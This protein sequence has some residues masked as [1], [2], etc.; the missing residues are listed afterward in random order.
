MSA[1]HGDTPLT[2]FLA[3]LTQTQLREMKAEV[4]REIEATQERLEH[5]QGELAQVEQ[6][7]VEAKSG[8]RR[9]VA[10]AATS[11]SSR[12]PVPIRSTDGPSMKQL[13]LEI[14]LTRPAGPWTS[15]EI[16]DELL[17]QSAAP[18]GDKPLNTIGNRLTEL[19]NRG[20]ITRVGRGEYRLRATDA[21]DSLFTANGGGDSD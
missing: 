2:R 11:R 7:M 14:M 17:A 4:R 15:K 13:I 20:Q 9:P 8:P 18:G 3:T 5:L 21:A 10:A 12:R 1:T 19:L 6:A 16:M